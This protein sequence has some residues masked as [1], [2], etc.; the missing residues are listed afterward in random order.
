MNN[1]NSG[2]PRAAAKTAL[3]EKLK[4]INAKFAEFIGDL[5]EL[6]KIKDTLYG[7]LA[8]KVTSTLTNLNEKGEFLMGDCVGLATFDAEDNL[9]LLETNI[10]VLSGGFD[11]DR[12]LMVI[13]RICEQV[14]AGKIPEPEVLITED[15][16]HGPIYKVSRAWID[17]HQK[18]FPEY[19]AESGMN[20]AAWHAGRKHFQRGPADR[21][22]F[23]F[24]P[25]A[26]MNLEGDVELKFY[27][28]TRVQ[29]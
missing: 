17:W 9:K 26:H 6:H 22:D 10:R 29:L 4:D 13:T 28:S 12:A 14:V 7:P 23:E 27:R 5:I 3:D 2:E 25:L 8:E 11:T 16:P 1:V 20:T 18:I 15:G 24:E 19:G 21:V